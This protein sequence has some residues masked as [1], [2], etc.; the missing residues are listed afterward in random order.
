[1]TPMALF[2]SPSAFPAPLVVPDDD[3]DIDPEWPPQSVKEWHQEEER[4]PVTSK[5]KTIYLVAPPIITDDMAAMKGWVAPGTKPT[6]ASRQQAENSELKM[7]D[8]Q[9]Y[10]AAFYHG[11]PVKVLNKSFSWH[12]WDTNGKQAYDGRTL[13]PEPKQE[14]LIGLRT[15][16]N[17]MIGVRCRLAPD[18]A[19][20][21]VNLDDIMDGLAEKVPTD[22]YAIMMLLDLDMYEGDDDIFTGGRAYGGP[23]IAVVSSFR[24][25]PMHGY[26]LNSLAHRWPASHCA[27]Y[28]ASLCNGQH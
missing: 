20:M 9:A 1:M 8:L 24:D 22:A 27:A 2:D 26:P 25:N 21:Q 18:R 14:R 4:N 15:P 12:N 17:T 6:P 10:V 28:V 13:K 16:A 5:K 3:L 19:A 11:M 7:A 23:R